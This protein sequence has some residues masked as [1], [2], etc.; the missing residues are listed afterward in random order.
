MLFVDVH[1]ADEI[2]RHEYVPLHKVDMIVLDEFVNYII[3]GGKFYNMR[4][5]EETGC[6]WDSI[7][8]I[9]AKGGD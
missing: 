1:C 4:Y 3:V 7:V 2:D 9:R 6:P 8:D 5:D